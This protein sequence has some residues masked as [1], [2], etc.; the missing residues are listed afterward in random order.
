MELLFPHRWLRVVSEPEIVE[1]AAELDAVLGSTLSQEPGALDAL[2]EYCRQKGDAATDQSE[3]YTWFFLRANFMPGFRSEVLNLLGFKQDEITSKFKAANN[4]DQSDQF[5]MLSRGESTETEAEL[6]T[7]TSTDLSDAHTLIERKLSNLELEPTAQNVVIPNGEDSTG[8]ICR[9]LVCGNLEEAVELCLEAKRVAD[10]LII[11]SLG[12]QE[13]FYKVQK[14]HLSHTAKDPV[15]LIAGSLLQ[16]QWQLLV[17]SAAA[18]SWRDVLGALVTH[19]DGDALQHYCEMLGD[20]LSQEKD[21]A[22]SEAATTCYLCAMS[23]DALVARWAARRARGAAPLAR[24]TGLALLARRAAA[25]RGRHAVSINMSADALVAR[26][27]ARRAR[28]PAPLARLTGLALLA[29]RAAAARGRHAVSINMSADALV[30]RWA[31]RR[32]REPAPLARLTGL[33]LLARR[34]AAARG[35]HAVS[36][37]M[38]AD[39]LVA[40]WAARRARGA[41]PLARL[42]GLALLARR[43]AAARGRH[44]VSINMSADA[45]VARWAA[46]RA[47]G[48]APWRASRGWRCWRGGRRPL[49]GATRSSGG[50]LDM[51]LTEYA[52]RLAAQGCLQSAL[53]S[54]EGVADNELRERLRHSLGLGQARRASHQPAPAQFGRTRTSSGP[55]KRGHL[56]AHNDV[57]NTYSAV[58]PSYDPNPWQAAPVTNTFQQPY[59]PP[60]PPRPGSVGPTAGVLQMRCQPRGLRWDTSSASNFTGCLTLH[61]ETQ[62]CKHCCFTAGLASKMVVAIR[63]DLAQGG[64]TSKSKYK[65]DPSVQSAPL[66]NQYSFNNPQPPSFGFNSPLPDQY[67]GATVPSAAFNQPNQF[68]P[69]NPSQL[70]QN[71]LNPNPLNSNPLNPNPL[72]PSQLNP[73]N[74]SQLNPMNPMNPSQLN[75]MNPS[76][77]NPMNPSQLN[78]VAP[79]PSQV[80][81]NYY[82]EP[83]RQAAPGWNDPP[84]LTAKPKPKQ[85]VQQ[86]AP[87]THPLFGVEPPQHVPL[88]P[89][90]PQQYP[91]QQF[92]GQYQQYP[93]QYDQHQGQYA[94]GTQYPQQTASPAPAPAPAVE[95]VPVQKA[96][97]PD[98]HAVMQSVLDAIRAECLNRAANPQMKRK[99]EDVQRRLE[100]LYDMLREY[101][102][103]G[104]CTRSAQIATTI[105]LANPA[106]KQQCLHCSVPAWRLSESALSSLHTCVQYAQS[107]DYD[108]ALHVTTS[109]ATG[110][111]FAAVASFLPGLKSLFQMAAQL[112][113]YAR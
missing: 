95:A 50:K 61:A 15:S 83:A 65:V 32:A 41:A 40:R 52:S 26:W 81:G 66:Y 112:Q 22:L 45:L 43:A 54:L 7:D 68:N 48:A 101:R 30:A 51:V 108:N 37:N 100:T 62:Q 49:G 28:G 58:P 9:A 21:P 47:R 74:P 93:G 80:N 113:V 17:Q 103:V 76:Q 20:R 84:L 97:I 25:A 69:L 82:Q 53:N 33:A 3:R 42:T 19:C 89:Q 24:L 90:Y 55:Q 10:A 64:I 4:A 63:A 44:A 38:S 111:D 73:L 12:S 70:N 78:P 13:L 60:Q 88:N 98:Q 104:P 46:R 1:C 5:A 96:P 27:A 87:I 29:R 11:A 23:A 99:L 77:L 105:S 16:S 6:S 57:S 18:T 59:T 31:A 86:Q 67:S 109:L 106:V 110:A 35:R 79:P 71:P 92:P 72:N 34:A 2:A 85:E 39:A 91:N 56:V 107:S 36:I 75:P 102:V 14:Y 94:P 8:L